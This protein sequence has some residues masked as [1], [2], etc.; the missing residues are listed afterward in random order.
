MKV[1]YLKDIVADTFTNKEGEKLYAILKPYL[2]RS[3]RITLSLKGSTAPSTSFLNSS[4][5]E[6]IEQYGFEKF[7]SIVSLTEA[8]KFQ[9]ESIKF[10]ITSCGVK[11]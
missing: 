4:I 6:L 2:D 9:A 10:Y 1:Y 7:R 3:E 5:G 8:T 11:V